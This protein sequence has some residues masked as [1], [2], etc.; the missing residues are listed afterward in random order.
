MNVPALFRASV[1]ELRIRVPPR[2]DLAE[3]PAPELQRG[4]VRE[5]SATVGNGQMREL[6]PAEA[7]QLL[8]LD[9][10]ACCATS[11]CGA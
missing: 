11:A 8:L 3:Q 1:A 9:D 7:G 5:P 6:Q 10:R 2:C 4:T